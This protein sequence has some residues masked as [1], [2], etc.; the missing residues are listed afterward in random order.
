M[1]ELTAEGLQHSITTTYTGV[2]ERRNG[3]AVFSY[4]RLPCNCYGILVWKCGV[5][6]YDLLPRKSSKSYYNDDKLIML[7]T[8]FNFEA[9]LLLVL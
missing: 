8:N 9:F 5:S 1:L 6:S 2:E 3:T 4:D 7:Q